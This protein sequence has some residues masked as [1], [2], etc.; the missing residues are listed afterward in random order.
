VQDSNGEANL[1]ITSQRVGKP[2]RR[3]EI[4]LAS[5]LTLQEFEKWAID[6]MGPIN[7]T[8]KHT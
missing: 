5:Q 2:Y 6:F 3:D 7:P 4:P 8:G 1:A